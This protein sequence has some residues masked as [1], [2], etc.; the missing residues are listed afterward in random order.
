[1]CAIV[2][3]REFQGTR[4]LI[5]STLHIPQ[6]QVGL[7]QL[8]VTLGKAGINLYRVGELNDRFAVLALA[9]I[10]FPTVEILLLARVGIT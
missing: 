6:L 8:R 1:V 5:V 9:K 3:W 10:L 4:Q 7:R 2:V